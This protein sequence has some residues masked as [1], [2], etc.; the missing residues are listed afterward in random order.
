MRPG[1]YAEPVYE[2]ARRLGV[3]LLP[4][5]FCASRDLWIHMST[6]PH[7]ECGKC[8]GGGPISK[9]HAGNTHQKI[10]LALTSWNVRPEAKP[11][12]NEIDRGELK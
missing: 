2:F 8:G 12:R 5:P 1:P 6:T 7:I 11:V 10:Y 3:E 9:R 4:C